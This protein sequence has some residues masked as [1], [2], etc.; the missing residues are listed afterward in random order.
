M[1]GSDIPE[2]EIPNALVTAVVQKPDSELIPGSAALV[3]ECSPLSACPSV[4]KSDTH[5]QTFV[6]DEKNVRAAE[7][8]VDEEAVHVDA[9]ALYE[10]AADQF[11]AKLSELKEVME[12]SNARVT[13]QLDPLD[14]AKAF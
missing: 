5:E 12:R 2:E 9:T 13:S 3:A 14:D 1:L 11:M 10:D 4:A 6:D 7:V 8:P